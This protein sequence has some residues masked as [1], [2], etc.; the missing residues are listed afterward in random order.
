MRAE[1]IFPAADLSEQISTAGKEASGTGNMKF[2]MNGVL[3]IGTLDVA[4]VEMLE[5]AGSDN[6]FIFGLKT[7]EVLSIKQSNSYNPWDYYNDNS[8]IRKIIDAVK[9]NIFSPQEP[10][11][12]DDLVDRIMGSD[13][14][15]PIVNPA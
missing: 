12:F 1:T 10:G 11:I 5:E 7:E 13:E 14:Y 8:E 9:S 15:F 4:N 3:T 6:I 2:M